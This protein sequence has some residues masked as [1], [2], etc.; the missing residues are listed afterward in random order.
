M[1]QITDPK[2]GDHSASA[3]G[4]AR[5]TTSSDSQSQALATEQAP[6]FAQEMARIPQEPLLGAEKKLIVGS[7]LLGL[8][9]LLVLYGI[10]QIFFAVP[11]TKP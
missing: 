2:E 10:S 7:L 11:A 9:L 5:G 8:V 3:P 4:L 6:N 1:T